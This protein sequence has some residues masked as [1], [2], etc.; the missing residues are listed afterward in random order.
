M[1]NIYHA[2]DSV[3]ETKMRFISDGKTELKTAFHFVYTL[4][5]IKRIFSL[6]GFRVRHIYN[7]LNREEYR[8][9][10]RQ[11]YLIAVKEQ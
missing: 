1:E 9:G 2:E 7:G 5:E 3:L 10:D 11:V 6:A 4:A 8:F